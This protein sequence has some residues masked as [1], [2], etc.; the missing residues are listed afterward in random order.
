M[1]S[2]DV[3][4]VDL[5]SNLQVPRVQMRRKLKGPAPLARDGS[6][7]TLPGNENNVEASRVSWAM[8]PDSVSTNDVSSDGLF[9][10]TMIGEIILPSNLTPSF[11]FGEFDLRVRDI[12]L[13]V[14]TALTDFMRI[15][16][17]W[18]CTL[19]PPQVSSL[20]MTTD[21][22]GRRLLSHPLSPMVRVQEHISLPVT[23]QNHDVTHQMMRLE[24]FTTL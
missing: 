17:S 1:K 16:I 10:R 12:L 7:R 2:L 3:Q 19:S 14:W 8:S 6:S 24:C 5:L 21:F 20:L 15:S 23:H 11:T 9:K 13:L 4:A 18:T 22:P